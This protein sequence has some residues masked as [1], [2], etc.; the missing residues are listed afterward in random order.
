MI[1]VGGCLLSFQVG[2]LLS[3]SLLFMDISNRVAMQ[4]YVT[5]PDVQAAHQQLT[6]KGVIG[7]SNPG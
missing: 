2:V 3:P 5:S 7:Q 1:S 4:L 6:E